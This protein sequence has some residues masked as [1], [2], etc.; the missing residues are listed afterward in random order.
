MSTMKKQ[1]EAREL[2]P[3]DLLRPMSER[4]SPRVAQ[5]LDRAVTKPR[6]VEAMADS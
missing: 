6:P 4:V 1:E 2:A 3:G 5:L